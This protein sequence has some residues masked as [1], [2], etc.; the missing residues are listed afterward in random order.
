MLLVLDIGNTNVKIGIFKNGQ[1]LHSWRMTTDARRT[2]D[3][4]G[5]QMESFFSHFELSTHDITGIIMSSVVPSVNYTIEHM[6]RLFF[7]GLEPLLV[8]HS[9]KTGLINLYETPESLGGDRI[10][11]SVAAYRLFGGPCIAIDFGTATSFNVITGRAEFLG[12]L[13]CPGIKVTSD[14]LT[15][16]AALLPKIEYIKPR[17]VICKNTID[18]IQ[19]GIINGYVGMIEHIISLINQE[20]GERH[21]VIATGGM[22]SII[23]SETS[24]IDTL[25]STLT[26][27]GL[28]IIADL[29]GIK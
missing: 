1:L 2:S 4:Y 24:F 8:N 26:L 22:S 9:V 5:I 14:A 21:K 29:N 23:A 16:S 13:I 27:E 25:A 6:C 17:S 15:S 19:S 18:A 3:E 7:H 20:R 28:A 10:C 12:G 11:N